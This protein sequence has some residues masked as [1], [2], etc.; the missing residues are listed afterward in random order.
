MMRKY[1]CMICFPLLYLSLAIT[2]CKIPALTEAPQPEKMPAAYPVAGDSVNTAKVEWRHFF[3]DKHL[4]SLID[5]AL[6]NNQELA[7]TLQ[8]IEIARNE[9]RM[10]HGRLLPTVEAGGGIGLEKTGR[11]TSQG[12]GDA[13]TEITPGKEVPEWLPDFLVGINASWEVDIWK[14]L[15]NAKEA[16]VKRYFSTVE[17]RNFIITNLI[18]EIAGSYYE[19]LALDSELNIVRQAVTLQKNA[20][21]IVRAQK[22]AAAATEL[23]VKKFEAEVLKSESLEYE[24]LRKI[25]SKEMEINH[26]LGRYPRPVE[27]DTTGILN[28]T[29]AGIASGIPSQLLNNRPDIRQAEMQLEAA[30]LDVAVAK[31]EFYPSLN[32]SGSLGFQ[33]FNPAFLTR[34]PESLLLSLAGEVAGPLIN[35]NAIRAEYFNANAR[36]IQAV[37]NYRR[38]VLNAY[39]EVATQ[40]SNLENYNKI[41]EIKSREVN[42]LTASIDIAGALFKNARAD[43]LEVLLTQRD[44]LESRLE[45]IESRL[46]QYNTVTNLY[47]AL[48]GGWN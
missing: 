13:S 17:G 12:A 22:Q 48:G 45:L 8:E 35:K 4:I 25:R 32:I 10:K 47:R 29:P 9:I 15:R 3:A 19:L 6:A 43:Y 38:T 34:L 2:G 39:T 20:L 28:L 46:D 41:F 11:Y 1:K 37:Y 5:T 27:R 24:V 18:A 36:Q 30:R 16:A 44:M 33:A 31:A 14:K 21:D 42:T 26:L 7:I 23:A 40:L